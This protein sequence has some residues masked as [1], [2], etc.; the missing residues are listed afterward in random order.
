MIFF[1]IICLTSVCL[2]SSQPISKSNSHPTSA[3]SPETNGKIAKSPQGKELLEKYV[4]QKVDQK[5]F[6]S[7][8]SILYWVR[9]ERQKYFVQTCLKRFKSRSLCIH[10]NVSFFIW[11]QIEA[12]RLWN[13]IM[14]HGTN[15]IKS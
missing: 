3:I 13:N 5:D 14:K 9:D 6:N 7:I 12:R 8:L 15:G 4:K 2:I 10:R 1:I 11:Q